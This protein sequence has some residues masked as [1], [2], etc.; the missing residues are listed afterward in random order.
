MLFLFKKELGLE[1]PEKTNWQKI[2]QIWK[3]L[4]NK[5]LSDLCKSVN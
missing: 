3:K 2:S 1:M 5:D 4:L